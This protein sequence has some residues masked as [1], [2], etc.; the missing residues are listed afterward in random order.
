MLVRESLLLAALDLMASSDTADL[1]KQLSRHM[2]RPELPALVRDRMT[3]MG[4]R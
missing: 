1:S 3:A 4:A 2:D